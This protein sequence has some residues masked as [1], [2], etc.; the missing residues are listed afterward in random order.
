MYVVIFEMLNQQTYVMHIT[1]SAILAGTEA[2][3]MLLNQAATCS[4]SITSTGL[5]GVNRALCQF[6]M[7]SLL[8][9]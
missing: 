4:S 7:L 3:L 2:C 5:S 9:I 1:E 6:S 8:G